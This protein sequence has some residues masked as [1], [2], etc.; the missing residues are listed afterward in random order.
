MHILNY[1]FNSYEFL[2]FQFPLIGIISVFMIMKY[3]DI[4]NSKTSEK[5]M[6]CK[7]LYYVT[8]LICAFTELCDGNMFKS[9][10]ILTDPV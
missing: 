5:D 7:D 2:F 9:K 4:L 1:I 3:N 6:V 8:Q 10:L